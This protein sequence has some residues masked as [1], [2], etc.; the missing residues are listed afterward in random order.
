MARLKKTRVVSMIRNDERIKKRS[1]L[2]GYA[3]NA[4]L[5]RFPGEKP[6]VYEPF[7]DEI[8]DYSW[9]E[10]SKRDIKDYNLLDLGI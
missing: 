9:D 5:Q 3:I 6:F 10:N 7:K 8:S 2:I 1:R 4:R